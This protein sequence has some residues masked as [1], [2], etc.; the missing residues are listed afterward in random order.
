[1]GDAVRSLRIAEPSDDFYGLLDEVRISDVARTA[2]WVGASYNNQNDPATF[3]TVGNEEP[4]V[5][6]RFRKSITIDR[7]KLKDIFN[8]GCGT[9]TLSDFPMLYSVTDA[10]LIQDTDCATAVDGP[11]DAEGD[12]I[13]FRALDTTTCGG[14]A[15]CTLD[16]EIEKYDG[17]TGEL[18]A[19]VRLPSVTV[20]VVTVE[21]TA[22]VSGGP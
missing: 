13:I 4:L 19:W 8:N 10:D 17:T 1:M 15:V 9:A 21:T 3:Y 7:T 6:Y 12:D 20:P 5:D 22:L 14:A 18:V 16:H 2:C 11:C